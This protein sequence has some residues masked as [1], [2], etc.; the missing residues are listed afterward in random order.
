MVST[1]RQM[2]AVAVLVCGFAVG[3]AG[4]LNYFKYR[5]TEMRLVKERLLVTGR[6]IENGIQSALALGLQFGDIG[7]LPGTLER[8]RATDDLILSIDVFDV[9]GHL[10]YSTDRLRTARPVPPAW[11]AA[12]K[13]AKAGKDDWFVEAANESAAGMSIENNFGLTIGY[14]ALR[15]SAEQIEESVQV[16]GRRLAL[17]SLLIFF[18][19][20]ALASAALLAVMNRLTR[21]IAL[22][23]TALKSSAPGQ[24]PSR[25]GAFGAMLHQFAE[26]VRDA[27]QQISDVRASLQ[28]ATAAGSPSPTAAPPPTLSC[29]GAASHRPGVPA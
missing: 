27:E 10:L 18:A 11:I 28:R 9:N 29:A 23:E 20:A 16:V 7:T 4:L 1:Q 15:Y 8:E 6:A 26:T 3:M 22:A 2:I 25:G 24:V 17:A 19:A 5:T 12:T 21:D 14:V 13:T